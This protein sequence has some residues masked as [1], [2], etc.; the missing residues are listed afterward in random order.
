[1]RHPLWQYLLV[2]L[3][4]GPLVGCQTTPGFTWSVSFTVP[5]TVQNNSIAHP[6]PAMPTTAYAVEGLPTPLVVQRQY[7]VSTP[8]APVM[9]MI[10]P[11][12]PI[13]REQIQTMPQAGPANPCKNPCQEE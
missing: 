1:M 3:G 4:L 5:P 12:P 13:Q 11:P 2:C 10:P 8:P 6:L 9:R 7:A